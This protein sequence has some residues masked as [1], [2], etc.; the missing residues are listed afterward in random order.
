M[1]VSVVVLD[2]LDQI[3]FDTEIMN[4]RVYLDAYAPLFVF[5]AFRCHIGEA[6]ENERGRSLED[7]GSHCISEFG[8]LNSSGRLLIE[9]T[10]WR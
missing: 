6:G 7:E 2:A 5:V 8:I 1:H 9:E 4:C 3:R 10:G